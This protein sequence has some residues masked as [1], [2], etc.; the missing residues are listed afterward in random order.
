MIIPHKRPQARDSGSQSSW[1]CCPA[2][3][4]SDT[5][6]RPRAWHSCAIKA[7]D[8]AALQALSAHLGMCGGQPG[9]EVLRHTVSQG[10]Q[11]LGSA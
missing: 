8:N 2:W 5:L 4:D 11:Y 9:S 7:P 1:Q 3:I 6:T 10:C